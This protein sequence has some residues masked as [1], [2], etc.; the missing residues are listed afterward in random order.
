[1]TTIGFIGLGN[2]G[3]HMAR[4]LLQADVDYQVKVFD[5][6]E[7]SMQSLTAATR[8]TATG[9]VA[10]VVAGADVVISMLPAGKHV[11]DV[12]LGAGGVL[13]NVGAEALLID[14]ST[15]DPATAREVAAQ[16][17]GKGLDMLDAPVSGGTAGAEAGTLTFIVGAEPT[18][19]ERARVYL[20]VMGAKIFHA[21]ASGAGQIAK[22]CNN[23]LLAIQMAGTAEAIG[24]GV[25]NGLDAGTLSEI[26]KQSSGGNWALN[27]YNPYPGVMAGAPAS[28]DYEGGFLVD[29]MTKDLG[30]AM[31]T[32]EDARCSVPMGAL[33]KN[34]YRLHQQTNDAGRLD[35]SSIQWLYS[36]NLKG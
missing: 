13:E 17:Q 29:L 18:G 32:A 35:F 6:V 31:E 23:M 11:L 30:L 20:E 14:C 1:M 24:L 26:M 34:L 19:L 28:R 27:V 33:A 15:I 10:E 25:E 22:I 21:G 16:A 36:P 3:G 7:S 5:V 12:Y 2:M 4:N 8:A 9:S